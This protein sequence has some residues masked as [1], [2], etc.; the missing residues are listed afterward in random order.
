M[1]AAL[2]CESSLGAAKTF[3]ITH[4][5]LDSMRALAVRS[6]RSIEMH[7][8]QPFPVELASVSS[9]PLNSFRISFDYSALSLFG[10]MHVEPLIAAVA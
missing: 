1:F 9:P 2:L 3:V 6:K 5:Y 8:R 7:T 10:D 4:R